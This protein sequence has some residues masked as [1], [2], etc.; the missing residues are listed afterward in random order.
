[1]MKTHK[2][3][4]NIY[5]IKL[6]EL[7]MEMHGLKLEVKLILHN[8]L[9]HSPWWRWRKPLK[10]ILDIHAKRPLLPSQPISMILKDK[11]PKMLVKLPILTLRESLMS[12]L[13]LHSLLVL[14]KQTEKFLLST[15]LEV[16]L[17][18]FQS[19]K[20]QAVSLK[21]KQ[22]MV[23]PHLEEKILIS[24]FNNSLLQN[25]RTS[26]V[27]IFQ[28]INSLFKELEKLLRKQ[29]LN[30]LLPLRPKLI[31]RIF[32]LIKMDQNICN[33]VFQELN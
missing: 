9:V 17:S 13:P 31:L 4:W 10:R 28:E 26:M 15:I 23:I 3:I 27:W 21:S 2:L 32:P 11:Q 12:Q 6:S 7:E 25:S 30:F 33:L 14:I 24:K 19:L 29:R 16:V 18:I 5:H 22:P 20:F 1:M 8:K